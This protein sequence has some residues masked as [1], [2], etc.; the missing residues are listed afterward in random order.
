MKT[1]ASWIKANPGVNA[2]MFERNYAKSFGFGKF[3]ELCGFRPATL[4]ASNFT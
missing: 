1:L 2:L 4:S 3:E